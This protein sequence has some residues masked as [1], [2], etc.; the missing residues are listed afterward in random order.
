M[1]SLQRLKTMIKSQ[2]LKPFSS[3]NALKKTRKNPKTQ[4]PNPKICDRDF[5]RKPET[6]G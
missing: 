6:Q 2:E 5:T 1:L 3:K 4:N